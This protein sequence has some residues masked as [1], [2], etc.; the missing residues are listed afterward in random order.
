MAH[1]GCGSD[2]LPSR[3]APLD[4]MGAG[5]TA[6][7]SLGGVAAEFVASGGVAVGVIS[8][9]VVPAVLLAPG[10]GGSGVACGVTGR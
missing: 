2:F 5:A 9:G 3:S 1:A 4:R 8:V 7:L 6:F 10:D